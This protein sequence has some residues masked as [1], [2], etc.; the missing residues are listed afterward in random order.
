[1]GE[2]KKSWPVLVAAGFHHVK[3]SSKVCVMFH[4]PAHAAQQQTRQLN[5]GEDHLGSW[6]CHAVPSCRKITHHSAALRGRQKAKESSSSHANEAHKASL[7]CWEL[8]R[9]NHH[10]PFHCLHAGVR[11]AWLSATRTLFVCHSGGQFIWL[12][13]C[14]KILSSQNWLEHRGRV[15]N[16]YMLLASRCHWLLEYQHYSYIFPVNNLILF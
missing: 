3:L 9:A 7:L 12:C 16:T 8:G 13:S 15:E 11:S 4:R 6:M 14:I 10:L 2:K 5:H 1:M